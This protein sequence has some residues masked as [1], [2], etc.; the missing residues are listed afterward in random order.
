VKNASRANVIHRQLISLIFC[1]DNNDAMPTP[2]PAQAYQIP[3]PSH[4]ALNHSN[5][6]PRCGPRLQCLQV[7]R[8]RFRRRKRNLTELS[9]ASSTIGKHVMALHREVLSTTLRYTSNL[10]IYYLSTACGNRLRWCICLYTAPQVRYLIDGT[11]PSSLLDY[12][13]LSS[14][15]SLSSV[16]PSASSFIFVLAF[17]FKESPF[18]TA[19]ASASPTFHTRASFTLLSLFSAFS[20]VQSSSLLINLAF[21]AGF[22]FYMINFPLNWLNCVSVKCTFPSRRLSTASSSILGLSIGGQ[23]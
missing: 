8:P 15:F 18:C 6:I 1:I 16:F 9:N 2:I 12:L 20:G 4:N 21:S 11:L 13:S 10:L 19:S 23:L 7:E 3:F 22:S 17:S 5:T 14:L